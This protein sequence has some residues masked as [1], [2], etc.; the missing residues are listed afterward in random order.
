MPDRCDYDLLHERFSGM[1]RKGRRCVISV[2]LDGVFSAA[3]LAHHFEWQVVGFYTIND[4]WVRRGVLAAG[5]SDPET[6][7]KGA[8]L[9]FLDHDI[10]RPWVDSIGHHLLQWSPDTPIPLHTDGLASLNPNL[11]RGITKKAFNRKYP[12]GT[13][14]FLLA[15][16]SDWGMLKDF[17][18]DDQITSLLLHIDSSF[19]NAMT[20]QDNALDWLNWLGGSE[21]HS[22][23]N[24]ICRRMLRFTPRTV[25]EQSRALAKRF[26]EFGIRPR[27][28]ASVSDPTDAEQMQ[29][30]QSLVGWFQRETGWEAQFPRIAASDLV[31]FTMD[32][33][34]T[35]PTKGEFVRVTQAEPFSYAIIGSDKKGLNY[36]WFA[37]LAPSAPKD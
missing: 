22:P 4:L 23:L 36:N 11:L 26:A 1:F 31:R 20:Y 37:G 33:R 19:I 24:P 18:P 5:V 35:N 6:A 13:F 28:Q 17:Q 12:Y 16:A 7:L 3:M 14:H 34:S 10:Y 8:D 21:E 9:I 30:L 29:R 15:C 27:S 2:D 25:L 32:R